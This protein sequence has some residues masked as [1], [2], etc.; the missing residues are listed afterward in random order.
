[1]APEQVSDQCQI[2]L[3]IK[4]ANLRPYPFGRTLW[5]TGVQYA[6][7]HMR[8]SCWDPFG[9]VSDQPTF[10]LAKSEG[11]SQYVVQFRDH[12]SLEYRGSEIRL[13]KDLPPNQACKILG[14]VQWLP[15]GELL[16][17]P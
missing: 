1:M 4:I 7:K 13:K 15:S 12:Q 6:R 3:G 14:F 5:K 16:Y 17:K 8:I 9:I 10:L 11:R 2:V